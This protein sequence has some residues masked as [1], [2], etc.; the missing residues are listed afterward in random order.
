M[1][2]EETKIITEI[3]NLLQFRKDPVIVV[4]G[5]TQSHPP[6]SFYR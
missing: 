5:G 3:V 6:I 1:V 4:D 2:E